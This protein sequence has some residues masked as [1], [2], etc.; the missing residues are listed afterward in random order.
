MPAITAVIYV[1]YIKVA[2]NNICGICWLV[3][4]FFFFPSVRPSRMSSSRWEVFCWQGAVCSTGSNCCASPLLLVL[5]LCRG[6]LWEG[7]GS[8]CV[9]PTIRTGGWGSSC[10]EGPTWH[11][12]SPNIPTGPS[13]ASQSL[14][15]EAAFQA[16]KWLDPRLHNGHTGSLV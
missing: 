1:C 16:G 4:L 14:Q 13:V 11:P 15:A 6:S 12:L 3:L 2:M 7:R 8:R 5:C 10:R 9:C